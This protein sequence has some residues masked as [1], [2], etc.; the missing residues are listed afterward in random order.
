MGGLEDFAW[1]QEGG[2]TGVEG[3][4]GNGAFAVAGLWVFTALV[5]ARQGGGVVRGKGGGVGVG[6]IWWVGGSSSS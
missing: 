1:G 4:D 6:G 3:V 5:P 2:P